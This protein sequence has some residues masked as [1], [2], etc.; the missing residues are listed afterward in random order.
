MCN[1]EFPDMP[2]GINQPIPSIGIGFKITIQPKNNPEI[3]PF[4]KMLIHENKKIIWN[5][6]YHGNGFTFF[7]SIEEA[8]R[9]IEYM[10]TYIFG[11]VRTNELTIIIRAVEYEKGI[12]KRPESDTSIHLKNLIALAK[13]CT[14]RDIVYSKT[15]SYDVGRVYYINQRKFWDINRIMQSNIYINPKY[16]DIIYSKEKTA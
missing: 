16:H 7:T 1:Y 11:L 3:T 9:Q 2:C 6:T 13:E 5:D 8:F 10:K 12:C 15:L 4:K 14:I